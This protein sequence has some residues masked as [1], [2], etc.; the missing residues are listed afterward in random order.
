M[1]LIKQDK[2]NTENNSESPHFSIRA[3]PQCHQFLTK[4][5]GAHA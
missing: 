1:S 3:I 4:N 2:Y 5:G